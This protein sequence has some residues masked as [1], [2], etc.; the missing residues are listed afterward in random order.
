MRVI[1]T[2]L[3]FYD[4]HRVRIGQE[5]ELDEASLKQD[6][7]GTKIMPSWVVQATD[8]EREKLKDAQRNQAKKEAAAARASAGPKRSEKGFASAIKEPDAEDLV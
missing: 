1:A 6:K 2:K 4:G 3:G 7:E 8:R 5:F